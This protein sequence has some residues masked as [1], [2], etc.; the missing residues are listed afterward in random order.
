[1]ENNGIKVTAEKMPVG[2]YTF[3]AFNNKYL[4]FVVVKD[5]LKESS[6]ETVREFTKH[7]DTVMLTGDNEASAREIAQKLG[8][9][10]YYAELL[11]EQ[12]LA[13]FNAIRTNSVSLYVGDGINDA[14]LLKNADIGVSM[15]SASD[16]AIEVSDIIIINND[17]RLLGMAINIAHKTRLIA[18]ENI[19][20]S[21]VVKLLFL[22]LSAFGIMFMWLSI[23]ADVG[24]TLLCIVNSLRI[25]YNK[26]YVTRAI[27][28]VQEI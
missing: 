26:R 27:K 11:P 2:S 23:F 21:M 14:P 3:I 9:I 22:V 18:T 17:I 19:V 5:E 8:G 16:L 7:Y 13:K 10:E 6:M 4:G 24:V 1:M 12:K 28:P 20:F 15:G 25:I